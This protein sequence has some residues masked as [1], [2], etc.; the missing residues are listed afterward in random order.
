MVDLVLMRA[1]GCRW[2]LVIGTAAVW[3]AAGV[4]PASASC[5]KGP[6]WDVENGS[7]ELPPNAFFVATVYL[8]SVGPVSLAV[9][10]DWVLRSETGDVPASIEH[11]YQGIGRAQLV[12]RPRRSLAP[13]AKYELA[14]G[15]DAR[16][17]EERPLWTVS[18]RWDRRP[19]RWTG[20][21]RVSDH[22]NLELGCG[23]ER[24]LTIQIP[25]EDDGYQLF[26]R[27]TIPIEGK[28]RS[29][30]FRVSDGSITV[31]RWMCSGAFHLEPGARYA[32]TLRLVDAAGNE[33]NDKRLDLQL[34][35]VAG[36]SGSWRK[37]RAEIDEVR[38]PLPST[39]LWTRLLWFAALPFV[40][41]YLSTT[42]FLAFHRRRRARR[43]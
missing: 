15:P 39:P 19:P 29:F 31:G 24:T 14:T 18:D 12:L 17:S 28:R 10:D 26:V 35:D 27:V 1:R 38:V 43:P 32:A 23:P 41:G 42:L 40:V 8:G 16:W 20:S 13:G 33:S 2:V 6:V 36:D 34:P 21:P 4:S 22:V 9:R 3:V 30:L 7:G 5:A 11:V 37:V 25:A